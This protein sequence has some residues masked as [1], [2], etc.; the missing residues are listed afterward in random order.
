MNYQET[1]EYL[2]N[3]DVFGWHP[4]L[5]RIEKLMEVLGNPEK[6]MRFVHIGGTNGKGSTTS[7]LV[8]AL[9]ANGY[10]TGMF[11]SPHLVSYRERMQINGEMV[12]K[13]RLVELTEKVKD[14]IKVMTD[15]GYEHPTGFEVSTA[16]AL[17]YFYEEKT[18]IAVIEVGL[19]GAID[20]TNVIIPAVSVITNV[21]LD[22]M[23]YL[24]DTVREI[25]TVKSGI[26]KEGVPVITASEDP[27]ALDVI[28]TKAKAMHA[29]YLRI[30]RELYYNVL[31]LREDGTRFL[32][33]DD[34]GYSIELQTPLVGVHQAVNG[35]T[36]MM[37]IKELEKQG[38]V[39][40]AEKTMEGFQKTFWPARLELV[41]TKPKILLDA[42]HNFDG[43]VKLR[44]SLNSIYKYDKL[45][46]VIGMLA[47]KQR[48]KVLAKLGPLA[49]SI[50]VTKPNS[51][52]AGDWEAMYKE[53]RNYTH[54]V[55]KDESIEGAVDKALSLAGEDDLVCIAGSIYM[56]AYAREYI[57]KLMKNS[58]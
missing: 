55:Y 10:K 43:A 3:L 17:L 26:I 36:V 21:T 24:G 53:A 39:F 33:K 9:R 46:Y 49:D 54:D 1:V 58:L 7:M 4:G 25:A 52:R 28:R 6:E 13:E 45:I 35:S 27:E 42:A 16:I 48:S 20:S 56:V 29:P 31:E 40:S 47:D 15:Q 12:P 50:V 23:F 18:D 34:Q 8:S 37:V 57:L 2:V 11:I 19:G 38:M 51:P 22:H 30:G 5:A 32:V 41:G 44:R 14:K